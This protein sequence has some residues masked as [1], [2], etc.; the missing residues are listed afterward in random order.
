MDD[1]AVEIEITKN[2]RVSKL[3]QDKVQWIQLSYHKN[4]TIDTS[5]FR[6]GIVYLYNK[7]PFI[8]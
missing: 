4:D 3:Q 7:T 6:S 8:Q 5:L 2:L 1:K